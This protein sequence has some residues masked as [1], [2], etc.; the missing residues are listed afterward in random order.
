MPKCLLFRA[1]YKCRSEFTFFREI[2]NFRVS[3]ATEILQSS[4]HLNIPSFQ[5]SFSGKMTKPLHCSREHNKVL[6]M[7]TPKSN[8]SMGTR[9]VVLLSILSVILLPVFTSV[10]NAQTL[11]NGSAD[12]DW[13]NASNWTAGL[14]GTSATAI[15]N[16]SGAGN[17]NVSLTGTPGNVDIGR[18]HFNSDA[19]NS[20]T[21]SGNA[22]NRLRLTTVNTPLDPQILVSTGSHTISH[23]AWANSTSGAAG[24]FEIAAAAQ[25]TIGDFDNTSS[26]NRHIRKEGA[27]TLI[28]QGSNSGFSGG[29]DINAGTV[30]L[31]NGTTTTNNR[32]SGTGGILT[33]TSITTRT[34]VSGSGST[35][36][37]EFSGTITGN[38]NY[39][40]GRP[41]F[42]DTNRQTLSG[43]NTYTGTTTV[44]TGTLLVMGSHT[45]GANYLVRS[46]T[47]N[48][49]TVEGVL[50][51]TGSITLANSSN[52]F[53]IEGFAA[54]R[55]GVIYAGANNTDTGTLTLGSST[56]ATTVNFNA[57]SVL[58]LDI[59]GVG[60]S[61]R[62]DIWGD[63]NIF[64]TNTTLDLKSLTGAWD[65]S[66]YTI[67]TFTGTR[68]G[69]FSS[70]VGLDS[71]YQINYLSESITLSLIPEPS[72]VLL[73]LSAGIALLVC[74]R[75]A[76]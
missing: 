47:N 52:T 15:F 13:Y 29:L 71:G 19:T 32:L 63:L 25:L 58:R 41:N 35:P 61:D 21:I 67:L 2:R 38:L 50:G 72:S 22:T 59:G 3:A 36:N 48:S 4:S 20:V 10:S 62:L 18:I 70:I 43:S 24:V 54:N 69:T 33:N 31:Q 65:G 68:T 56:V 14:P 37:Y 7:R 74:R 55:R 39:Q 53:T 73:I 17:L 28:L 23:L 27:G 30:D 1:D 57:H 49:H 51:G 8:H 75:L 6:F 26:N 34:V 9:Q 40:K 64:G 66:T 45:G 76:A 60:N 46:S 5:F 42:Q 44:N 11:W 12:A 16:T